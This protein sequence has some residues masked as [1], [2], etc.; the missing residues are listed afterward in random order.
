LLHQSWQQ[1]LRICLGF[2]TADSY[3]GEGQ[4][5]VTAI[6]GDVRTN[7]SQYDFLKRKQESTETEPE[8][9]NNITIY[10]YKYSVC[11]RKYD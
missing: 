8:S 7:S 4:V 10:N 11:R 3:T 6:D 5:P 2:A 1:R 9:D